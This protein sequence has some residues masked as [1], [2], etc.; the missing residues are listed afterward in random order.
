M[1][2]YWTNYVTTAANGSNQTFTFPTEDDYRVRHLKKVYCGIQ[3]AGVAVS[4]FTSGQE[5][6]TV[7]STRFAAGNEPVAV[8]F[9]IQPRIQLTVGIQDLSATARTN[10][11]IVIEY[12]VD[13]AP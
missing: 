13:S 7:D 6:S 12:E 11:P 9:D 1:R 10:V 4:F 5:Y 8:E 2:R 3:V